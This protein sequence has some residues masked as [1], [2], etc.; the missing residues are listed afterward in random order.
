ME[1]V[2]IRSINEKIKEE[3]A[4]V[5]ALTPGNQQGHRWSKT[6]G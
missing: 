3:S 5:D 1:T 4:F 6:H 2:D